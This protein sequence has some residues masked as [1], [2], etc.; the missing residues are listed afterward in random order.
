MKAL[1]MED[2]VQIRERIEKGIPWKRYGISEVYTAKNGEIGFEMA[3]K[4]HPEIIF[5]D[6]R[7]PRLGGISAAKKLRKITPDCSIIFVSA[8]PE[9]QYFKEAIRLKAVSFVEKPINMQELQQVLSEAIKEQKQNRHQQ[10]QNEKAWMYRTQILVQR[11]CRNSFT[12]KAE[13]QEE[14]K[15]LDIDEMEYHFF[16]SAIVMYMGRDEGEDKNGWELYCMKQEQRL[17]E[18]S[19]QVIGAQKQENCIV[20]HF[21]LRSEKEKEEAIQ[22]LLEMIEGLARFYV[23]VGGTK[24][25]ASRLSDSYRDAVLM[26]NRAFFAPYGKVI[27]GQ[28]EEIAM[29]FDFSSWKA[30]FTEVLGRKNYEQL[31]KCMENYRQQ[32]LLSK[33]IHYIAVRKFYLYFLAADLLF[34]H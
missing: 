28:E 24:T 18:T 13:R 33:K 11:L 20:Y 8:Y 21:F 17:K 31:K 2:E 15:K 9:K 22:W 7:M 34:H 3:K 5:A 19:L 16:F 1:I 26:E 10:D 4:F 6:I 23:L 29:N 12:D 30:E 27:Q 32:I 25:S 14:L